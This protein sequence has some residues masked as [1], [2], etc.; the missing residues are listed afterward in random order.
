MNHKLIR[1]LLSSLFFV[2][3]FG[4][5]ITT[6]QPIQELPA[7][8][9]LENAIQVALANNPQINW[10][11]LSVDDANQLVN[12]ARSEV[13][14]NISSSLTYTRNFE[15]PVQ[16]LPSEFVGLPPGDLVPI[17]FGTDNNWQ[18]G[19]SVSQNLFK[20]EVIVALSSSAVFKTVQEENLRAVSQQ[21]IGRA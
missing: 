18:G 14:P 10:A 8:L 3:V 7:Q 2:S 9:S 12:I 4:I 19:F 17:S 1:L 5:K 15:I 13:Y 11:I 16:F 21:K 6:A 20:G